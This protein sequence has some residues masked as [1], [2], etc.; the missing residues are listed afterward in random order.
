M[1]YPFLLMN[2]ITILGLAILYFQ[3]YLLGKRTN[4]IG[5]FKASMMKTSVE[6][7]GTCIRGGEYDKPR[8]K[9]GWA[10]YFTECSYYYI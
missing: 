7:M 8:E 6:I 4:T 2:S 3:V 9:P 1:K 10:T 5:G